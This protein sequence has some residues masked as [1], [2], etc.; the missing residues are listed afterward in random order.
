[1][2]IFSL[3]FQ[4]SD[5]ENDDIDEELDIASCRSDMI[6]IS[7]CKKHKTPL[8]KGPLKSIEQPLGFGKDCFYMCIY[9]GRWML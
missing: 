6:V 3:S 7:P 2:S 5:V 1:M 8:E 9:N 4:I